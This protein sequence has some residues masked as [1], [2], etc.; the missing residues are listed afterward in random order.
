MNLKM[1][2]FYGIGQEP[3]EFFVKHVV[4]STSSMKWELMDIRW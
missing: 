2:V 3:T 1:G 4:L